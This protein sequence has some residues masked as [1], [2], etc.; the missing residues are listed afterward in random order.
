MWR[1]F[2]M[3]IQAG[4]CEDVYSDDRSGDGELQR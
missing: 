1:L 3:S 4:Q 2:F